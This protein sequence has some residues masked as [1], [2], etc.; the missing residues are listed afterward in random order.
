MTL[1]ISERMCLLFSGDRGESGLK[2][3]VMGGEVSSPLVFFGR[4]GGTKILGILE[5]S[6]LG[7]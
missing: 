3:L 4:P 6:N 1:G 2:S 5:I 7:M